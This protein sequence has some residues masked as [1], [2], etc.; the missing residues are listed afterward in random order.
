MKKF[1][2]IFILLIIAAG[3]AFYFG[4][5]RVEPGTFAVAH[6]TI[7]GTLDYP[8]ET[9]RIHWIWQKLIPKTF[10]LYEIQKE[11]FTA[12][13]ES[14]TALPR[15][16]NLTDFGT[17]RLTMN[18]KL[19]YRI[20]FDS[21]VTILSE[22]SIEDFH[23]Q[24]KDEVS[25]IVN[26][27]ASTFVVEGMTRY[28]Y[29]VR[30]FDYSVLDSLKTELEKSILRHSGKYKLADVSV[31]IIF[32][33]IPQLDVYAEALK[34]YYQ[35]LERLYALKEEELKGESAYKEKQREE[36][37]EFYR[38][39]KYGEL[40]EE[41]PDL[42]KY[43]YIQKF[44]EKAEVMV[45]PQD[46]ATGFPKMLETEKTPSEKPAPEAKKPQPE[47]TPKPET[48]PEQEPEGAERAVEQKEPQPV[49]PKKW[50][51]YLMFWKNEKEVKEGDDNQEK[52]EE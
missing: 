43:F 11:P 36:D 9:G 42:L 7:T 28:T 17:F 3:V 13:I 5:V 2:T 12:E 33:E 19:Q 29:N 37:I 23:S 49:E 39:K 27:T 34:K 31:S 51:E 18:V 22:G 40:I 20:D 44:G 6:S 35:F 8:L 14:S 25:S 50:Y 52:T 1:I 45:L 10:Y 41:Y 4:W 15:S 21:A 32:T 26:E 46:E 38:L 24:Y 16:E 48:A 30:T 47:E